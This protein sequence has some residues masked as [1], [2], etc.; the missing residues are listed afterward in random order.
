LFFTFVLT[1]ADS[2]IA[3]I[4]NRRGFDIMTRSTR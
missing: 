2:G 3:I 4:I 1:N